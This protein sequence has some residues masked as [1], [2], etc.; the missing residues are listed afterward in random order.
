M[1]GDFL[2]AFVKFGGD[3]AIQSLRNPARAS[4]DPVGCRA[5]NNVTG[6]Y[7]RSSGGS[8]EAERK[9]SEPRAIFFSD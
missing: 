9:T 8:T 1:V 2:F 5:I 6:D 4:A 3:K 7:W